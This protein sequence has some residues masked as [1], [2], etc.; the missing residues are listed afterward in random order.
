[1]INLRFRI[2]AGASLAACL[3]SAT[4][5]QAQTDTD[6]PE[7]GEIIVT[8]QK[9]SAPLQDVALSI[10]AFSA[11]T[12]ERAG[13]TDFRDYA[14]R[15]PNIAFS[16]SNSTTAGSQAI[17]IRG[18]FGSN[19]TGVYLDEVPLPASVDP[20]VADIARIEV[21]RGPQG[22]LY[23]ARS[24]GGT[25]RLI[26]EQPDLSAFSG[27]ARAIASN[28]REGA[29]NGSSD[30]ILN[31]PVVTEVFALRANLFYDHQSGVF[32]RVAS[33]NAPVNFG[34]NENVDKSTRFG[35]QIAGRLSLIDDRLTLSPRFTFEKGDTFGRSYADV[36]PGNFIHSRLFD[37]DERGSNDWQ[38]YSLTG[39][40]E[41]SYGTFVSS[42]SQFNRDYD[43]S[44]DFAEFASFAFGVPPSLSVIR[45]ST[46]F[47]AFAQELRFVSD[48]DGPFQIT[49]GAFYQNSNNLQLF[50]P[51]P[52]GDIFDNIFSQRLETRVKETAFFGEAKYELT[53]GLRL[54]IGARWFDN[55]VDFEG[56]QD[57][58]AV[59]PDSFAGVQ[60]ETDINPK[61]Q[62]EY[63][64]TKDVL[65]YANAAKGF[66]IGGVNSYSNLLCGPDLTRLGLTA[67]QAQ[68][69][70]SDSLWS[71]ELG[72]KTMWAQ[73]RLTLN[74]AAYSIEWNGVQQ[75]VP[76]PACGFNLTLNAG[77]AKIQGFEL[78]T[79]WRL[80]NSLTIS[81]GLGFADSEVTDGGN[82]GT[83]IPTG[84]PVQQVPRWTYTLG[85]DQEF[86]LGSLPGY[87]RSDYSYVGKSFSAN[88]DAVN[89]RVRPAYSIANVRGGLTIGQWGL[90]V[91]V[92]NVFNE[93]ANL[94][95]VPPLAIELPGRPRI[96]TNR[97]RTIGIE[98]RLS[99]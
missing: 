62:V 33:A 28:T 87:L 4:S 22:T 47:E 84:V 16:Y 82:F 40:Y 44:E 57:G 42:T 18:V 26:T 75:L 45:T 5:A 58:I 12:I 77:A 85:V 1:M 29:W 43:D 13:I 19:T 21:L 9:R 66:R 63:D 6:V 94:S 38:L 99:F 39:E 95:D 2:W 53:P 11:E 17:A 98:T 35:G 10:T 27:R 64:V 48:F 32:D 74:V 88:N 49:L 92:D 86:S 24:M 90:A 81:G 25:V 72:A 34:T 78:E 3:A 70:N 14:L 30:I 89:R 71:Y 67:E 65:L 15:T 91:F 83:S 59:S 36:R 51:T 60:S 52:V 41:T 56:E 37:I 23:G 73:R 50:P 93:H 54:T 79:S 20:R 76:L 8:A 97:P 80:T 31:I 61:Y 55:K 69:F 68:S 46:D 7:S 96:A